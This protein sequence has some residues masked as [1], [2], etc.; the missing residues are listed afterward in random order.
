MKKETLEKAN[1]LAQAIKN[2]TEHHAD[3]LKVLT[4]EQSGGYTRIRVEPANGNY[5]TRAL[6]SDL[7]YVP[8]NTFVEIYLQAVK[9]KIEKLEAEFNS[10]KD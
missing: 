2:L 9:A 1:A 7:L 8:I 6:N 4:E 5:S 3:V 10:L